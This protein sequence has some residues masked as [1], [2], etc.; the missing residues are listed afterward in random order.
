MVPSFLVA[1]GLQSLLG[2]A[3]LRGE[4]ISFRL[5]DQH[6]VGVILIVEHKDEDKAH[7]QELHVDMGV[8]PRGGLHFE[9]EIL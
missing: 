4:S 6:M 1:H 7:A 5:I 8:V 9:G 3:K 2:L